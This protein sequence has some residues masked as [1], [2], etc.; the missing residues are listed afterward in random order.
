[1]SILFKNRNYHRHPAFGQMLEISLSCYVK[2]LEL[3]HK[4]VYIEWQDVRFLWDDMGRSMG[5]FKIPES[6]G[7]PFT[8]ISPEDN[9]DVDNIIDIGLK[10]CL[11]EGCDPI[12]SETGCSMRTCQEYI[13]DYIKRNKELPD[14]K[15]IDSIDDIKDPY[16]LLHYR[17][18]FKEK[19]KFRNVNS[20]WYARIIRYIRKNYDIEIY[21]VGEQ[22]KIDSLCDRVYEYCMEDATEIFELVNRCK[23]YIGCPSGPWIIPIYI[24][25]PILSMVET[26]KSYKNEVDGIGDLLS[27]NQHL[28]HIKK[29]NYKEMYKIIDKY[30]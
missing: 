15:F 20:V 3:G 13:K 19:Q 17:Y 10:D 9:V 29:D 25:K 16:I 26:E 12:I 5:G 8:Y 4:E 1:M 22:S 14:I 21:K 2:A 7:L 23:L 24:R 30:I 18:S 6:E 28:F 11:Y 27:D